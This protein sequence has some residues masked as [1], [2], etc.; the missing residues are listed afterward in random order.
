MST[1]FVLISLCATSVFF[2]SLWLSFPNQAFTTKT[3]RAQR[4]HKGFELNGYSHFA[5]MFLVLSSS[6]LGAAQQADQGNTE[7]S[8]ANNSA[9][10]T[11]TRPAADDRSEERR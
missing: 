1:S 9:P 6:T 2:V 4:M 11:A 3:Q 8:V 7:K 10:A 5:A